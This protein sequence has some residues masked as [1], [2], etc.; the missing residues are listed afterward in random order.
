[1]ASTFVVEDGTGL[2]AANSLLSVADADLID[3]N[4]T[5]S[6]LWVAATSAVKENALREATRY[7]NYEYVWNG[8]K[9]VLD[10]GCQWPRS[11]VYDE[12]YNYV[13]SASIPQRVQE[14]CLYLAV[15]VV[16]GDTLLPDFTN[17]S[18]IK[19]SKE[20]VG[21]LTDEKE[22]V[23]GESPDKTYTTADKLVSPFVTGEFGD[24]INATDIIRG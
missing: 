15:K 12:D 13:D 24:D 3:E 11:E 16:E 20:V 21:P 19:K 9:V 8:F 17:E 1:M 4:F 10:Q 7:L 23:T 18:K 14:A 22:Y 2:E 5:S 6:A